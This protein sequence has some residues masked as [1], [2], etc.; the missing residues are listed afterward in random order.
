MNVWLQKSASIQL[1][2][3]R[4]KLSRRQSRG[5]CGMRWRSRSA[6]GSQAAELLEIWLRELPDLEE[7]N[8]SPR[9]ADREAKNPS[10]ILVSNYYLFEARFL[11]YQSRFLQPNTHFAAF[12]EIYKICILSQRSSNEISNFQ[13]LNTLANFLFL[14]SNF[15]N[16][17]PEILLILLIFVEMFTKIY[18]SCGDF[19]FFFFSTTG[20]AGRLSRVAGIW[21]TITAKC[22]ILE[23]FSNLNGAK[24]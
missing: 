12:F 4:L 6:D 17:L 23:I 21:W 19:F 5:E 13:K 16:F 9:R 22:E 11:L 2:T 3:A 14:F 1:R 20:R 15:L 8:L 7:R 10:T 24:V 18:L